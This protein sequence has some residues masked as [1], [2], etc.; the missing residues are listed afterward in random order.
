MMIVAI[1][2]VAVLV[3]LVVAIT[4]IVCV[5]LYSAARYGNTSRLEEI[6]AQLEAWNT[7]KHANPVEIHERLVALENRAGIMIG[8]RR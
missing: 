6:E 1:S 5:H 8:T 7:K 2:I 3:T 4:S